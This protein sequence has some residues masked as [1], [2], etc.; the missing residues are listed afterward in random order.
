MIYDYVFVTMTKRVWKNVNGKSNINQ[1]HSLFCTLKK[2]LILE[3][4]CDYLIYLP[5][6]SFF[7]A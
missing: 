1:I 3:E 7:R 4:K 6:V 5:F 2:H